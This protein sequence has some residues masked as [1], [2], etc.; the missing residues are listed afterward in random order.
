[1]HACKKDNRW[2]DE[3]LCYPSAFQTTRLIL[4]CCVYSLYPEWAANISKSRRRRGRREA[5]GLRHGLLFLISTPTTVHGNEKEG[6]CCVTMD[7]VREG[8]GSG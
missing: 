1:M 6:K 7:G 3:W 2:M 8:G 4:L 5:A